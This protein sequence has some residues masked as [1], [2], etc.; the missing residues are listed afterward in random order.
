[1]EK[2]FH[3]VCT[4]FFENPKST[5]PSKSFSIIH[6]FINCYKR[7]SKEIDIR[8]QAEQT[9]LK[10]DQLKLNQEKL[11]TISSSIAEGEYT[12]DQNNTNALSNSYKLRLI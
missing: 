2:Q 3:E 4:L 8:K 10:T 5:E 12:I 1:M 7:P 6:K 11:W 9:L